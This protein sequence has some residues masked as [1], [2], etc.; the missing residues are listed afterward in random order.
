MLKAK[1]PWVK[2]LVEGR[3]DRR[4]ELCRVA[5]KSAFRPKVRPLTKMQAARLGATSPC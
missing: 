5:A 1:L 4:T 2:S 3:F